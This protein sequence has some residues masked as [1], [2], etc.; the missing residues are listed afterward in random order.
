[1]G[2]INSV[3]ETVDHVFNMVSEFFFFRK[4]DQEMRAVGYL[5]YPNGDLEE[6]R[7]QLHE[8]LQ[9]V[10]APVLNR[11]WYVTSIHK[12]K[13][14]NT[15]FL[16]FK[17]YRTM[18]VSGRLNPVKVDKVTASLRY[19]RR[20]ET[21]TFKDLETTV[22][23]NI[24]DSELAGEISNVIHG[25]FR[26]KTMEFVM[27]VGNRRWVLSMIASFCVGALFGVFAYASYILG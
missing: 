17:G 23:L 6:I 24:L 15:V 9:W 5:I 18:Q 2:L 1:M 25:V 26:S 16:P 4:K 22:D 19:M 8:S 14:K 27:E 21:L 7:V 13:G 11:F 3:S 10:Y 12:L 20:W